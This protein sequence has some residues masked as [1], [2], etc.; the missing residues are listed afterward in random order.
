[1]TKI[2]EVDGRSILHC[3][4]NNQN[5]DTYYVL[6]LI[7]CTE[8]EVY[9]E[10]AYHGLGVAYPKYLGKKVF[11]FLD[12]VVITV[13]PHVQFFTTYTPARTAIHVRHLASSRA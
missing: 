1:M 11:T 5:N 6:A 2:V 4:W 13:H 3:H 7:T 10:G 8:L 12:V 9:I